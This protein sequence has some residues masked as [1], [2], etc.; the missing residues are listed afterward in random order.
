LSKTLHFNFENVELAKITPNI[1]SLSLNGLING[2]LDYNEIYNQLKPSANLS[3]S[4]FEINKSEQ[5]NL[6]VNVTGK[7]SLK[8]Y[9]VDIELNREGIT[10]FSAL[11][12]LDFTSDKPALDLSL[13]FQA[14]KLDA[15]SPLGEDVFTNIKGFAY[16]D[17]N[18]TGLIEN[19]DMDGTLFLDRAALYF[20]YLNVTYGFEGTSVI[21][22][23]KQEF[24]FFDVSLVDSEYNTK[25]DLKG[26]LSH[27]YFDNWELDLLINTQNLLVLDT[28][29]K[30][31]SVYYGTGFLEGEATIKGRTDK[32]VIDVNGRTKKNTHFVIPISDVKTVE[33]S[34]LIRFINE[35]SEEEIEEV[36]R[37]FISEK[38]KGLSLNFNMEVTKDAIVEM[39]LDKS[40]G[41]Y[42]KGSG[43]GNLIIELDTKDKFDMYGDFLVD[44]GIY[45]FKY[46]GFINKPF[47]VK[48]GGNISWN[49]DPFTAD[50]D[51]EAVYRVSANPRSLLE[52]ISANRK[53][54]ID[55]I[56]RFS[57]ELFNSER[58][59]DIEIPNASSTV[60]SELEFKLNN[61]D[62]NVKTRHFVS[63]L[64]TGAF[65]NDSDFSI[66]TSGLVYGTATDLLSNAFD[67]IFNQ[68]NSKFK[69]KPVYTFGEKNK[70]DNLNIDDQLSLAL[71]YQLND[72]V[73][74]NGKV[75]MPI[76]SK[77]QSSVIGEVNV[78]FLMNEEGTLKSSIFNR[79]NEI[80]YTEEE[81]GYTQGVGLSYQID[82]DNSK[83]LF[84]K[85]GLKRRS[86]SIDSTSIKKVKDSLLIKKE[87]INFASKKNNNK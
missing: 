74:I 49:G 43:T 19:P 12:E 77:E 53:I 24:N 29:E 32:L 25:G 30:E 10:S 3:I 52:N 70:V 44:N 35:D 85:L 42:L 9:D 71:D 67:N 33:S 50:I 45:N 82:F 20:P 26:T 83:E 57:G 69:L 38:L 55:L 18:L 66:N 2:S 81:E 4:N 13:N 79:Q 27:S 48:K 40:T 86:K 80:Q 68:G 54:P 17:V 78:E 62:E 51:I 76:G 64:A 73:I 14:F 47:I 72:R 23:A 5:G 28:E 58:A 60:A 1:D 16:G 56:T 7:N 36:R 15:F 31:N 8:N 59:F 61:N 46:G 21:E 6:F 37:A 41:S 39:V 63:L 22:L 34:Q 65:Y 11:G 75:G 84:E 87:L